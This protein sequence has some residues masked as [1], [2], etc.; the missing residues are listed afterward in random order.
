MVKIGIFDSLT[1]NNPSRSDD[2]H[3]PVSWIYIEAKLTGSPV[4]LLN[5]SPL[6]TCGDCAKIP[7]AKANKHRLTAIFFNIK[8]VSGFSGSGM[9][10]RDILLTENTI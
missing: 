8:T 9:P 5:N 1:T 10:G 6:I 7:D 4:L 3:E 2:V